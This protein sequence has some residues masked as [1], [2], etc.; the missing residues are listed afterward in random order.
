[1][2]SIL[3]KYADLLVNYCV[4][5]KSGDKLYVRS[6]TLAEPLIREVYRAATKAGA[7]VEIDLD[8][9]EKNRIFLTEAQEHQLQRVPPMQKMAM[10]TFD[11]YIYIRAPFN[12]KEDQ[13]I[14]KGKS[15]IRSKAMKP[16]SKRYFERTA[17]RELKR[18]L[19]QYPTL[20][21]AQNADMSL[22]EY[23]QFIY[24]ACNLYTEDPQQA[25]L[26]RRKDQQKIV[27]LLNKKD[28][29]QYKGDGIDLTFSTKERTW[30][31]SDGQTNMPSGEVYTSPVEDSVNGVVHFSFPAVYMGHE[32]EGV[33]LWVK[34]GYVE[35]WEAKRGQKFMDNILQTAGARRFGE[36]AIG[37][38]YNINRF[39]KNILFDEKIGGTIHLAL[40]QSYLQTGGKNQSAIHW[41]MIGN[42]V[43]GGQIFADDEMIYE[44]GQFLF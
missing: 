26:N 13:N 17:T 7:H 19:C 41:D 5:I 16:V 3:K 6:T 22:E 18:N 37:T 30:I 4:E 9:R 12:L 33:T 31:N 20:A 39:T 14:P 34:D 43:N 15:S 23:Q 28:K 24:G 21:A 40:G 35:K 11:A 1:M 27:D 10:E 29:I 36:A 2:D 38:N 42:M 32:V 8:F 25:W 44:N